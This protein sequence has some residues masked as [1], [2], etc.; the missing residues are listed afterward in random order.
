MRNTYRAMEVTSPGVFSLVERKIAVPSAGQ[1]RIRVE[2][3]GVFHFDPATVEAKFPHLFSSP[4]PGHGGIRRIKKMGKLTF[5]GASS[6]M[7][8]PKPERAHPE[9]PVT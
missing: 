2:A 9:T 8:K 4:A 1:V 7:P 3:C 6:P 5:S